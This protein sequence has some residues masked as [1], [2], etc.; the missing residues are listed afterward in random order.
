MAGS[1]ACR[2][3]VVQAARSSAPLL[4]GGRQLL[5][6]RQLA[7]L[8]SGGLR[9]LAITPRHTRQRRLLQLRPLLAER[10]VRAQ[11][12]LTQSLVQRRGLEYFVWHALVIGLRSG[13]GVAA[14][15][16]RSRAAAG[17]RV[18]TLRGHLLLA[19]PAESSVEGLDVAEDGAAPATRLRRGHR[20]VGAAAWTAARD[21]HTDVVNEH[22]RDPISYTAGQPYIAAI[23]AGLG[24]PTGARGCKWR[25]TSSS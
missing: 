16:T 6:E 4:P 9:S 17:Q 21:A 2:A 1:C 23:A 22:N 18:V 15:W 20:A 25:G 5:R 11:E 8:G 7:G 13:G 10:S 24:I 12:R 3:D 19:Q 14:L